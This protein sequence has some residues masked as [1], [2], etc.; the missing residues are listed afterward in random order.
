MIGYVA[1]GSG[2][3]GAEAEKKP[4]GLPPQLDAKFP[5]VVVGM[6]ER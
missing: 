2:G 3:V 1:G 4:S 5:G 6:K